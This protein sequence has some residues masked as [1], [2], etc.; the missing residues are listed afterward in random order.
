MQSLVEIARQEYDTMGQYLQQIF[1][2][3]SERV[4]SDDMKVGCQ[5]IEFWTTI[6]E[7]EAARLEKGANIHNF[8]TN[9]KEFL[10]PLLLNTIKSVDE[11]QDE[12]EWG[13]NK[14]AGC[15]L[16]KCALIL[17]NDIMGPIVAFISENIVQEDWKLRYAS[18][19]ALG[20][21]SEGPEKAKF[22]EVIVPSLA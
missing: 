11:F 4:V 17:K 10:I 16:Q 21:I 3:T 18:L 5:S 19:M 12:D 2:I 7:V 6:G 14:A 9:M 8:I 15:C 22:A 13:V 20:A 1:K